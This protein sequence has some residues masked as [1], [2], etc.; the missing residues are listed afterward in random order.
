MFQHYPYMQ[1]NG[2]IIPTN[3]E[4]DD[5]IL[6]SDKVELD[7]EIV[8]DEN[9]RLVLPKVFDEKGINKGEIILGHARSME[10]REKFT[11]PLGEDKYMIQVGNGN[12]GLSKSTL[13][14]TYILF[15]KNNNYS[16]FINII[17]TDENKKNAEIEVAIKPNLQNSGL[18]TKITNA[19]YNELFKVGYSSITSA[20]FD[21]NIPSLKMHEKVASFNGVRVGS[22]YINGK[23]WDMKFFTKVNPIIEKKK[24]VIA[25]RRDKNYEQK[26]RVRRRFKLH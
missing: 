3:E 5:S 16:G 17:G 7:N 18:G 21:F 12:Y 14:Y 19:F 11:I 2:M 24:N 26:E 10:E 15:D 1:S 6:N 4:I 23:L 9:Y 20:I 13:N 25:N 8:I 22:Y